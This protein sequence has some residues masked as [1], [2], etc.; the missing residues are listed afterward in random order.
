[1]LWPGVFDDHFADFLPELRPLVRR[2]FCAISLGV[3]STKGSYLEV[4]SALSIGHGYGHS[5]HL[6]L[7]RDPAGGSDGGTGLI[8]QSCSVQV[9]YAIRYPLT[10]APCS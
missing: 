1:M 7:L 3:L 10:R 5:R 2:R 4:A 6:Q 9:R 8:P